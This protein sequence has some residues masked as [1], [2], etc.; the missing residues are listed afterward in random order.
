MKVKKFGV[1]ISVKYLE[2]NLDV[3][4]RIFSLLGKKGIKPFKF[5]I[6]NIEKVKSKNLTERTDPIVEGTK[7]QLRNVDFAIADFTDKSRFVFFQTITA[8]ESRVPVL[9][10]CK[11]G[12][13]DNIPK[14]LQSYGS[15]YVKIRSYKNLNDIDTILDEYISNVEPPKRRFNIVLRTSVLKQLEQLCDELDVSKAEL[16]RRLIRKEYRNVFGKSVM[17]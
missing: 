6:L 4:K 5:D 17:N 16:I 2:K 7:R 12:K 13:E 8:L 10:L 3:Y 9:C 1:F 11:E 15:D 14:H